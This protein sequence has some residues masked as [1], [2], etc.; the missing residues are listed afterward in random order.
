[1]PDMTEA[2]KIVG[3]RFR[4]VKGLLIFDLSFWLFWCVVLMFGSADG[5]GWHILLLTVACFLMFALPFLPLLNVLK[6]WRAARRDLKNNRLMEKRIR[7][8]VVQYKSG[9]R[10][11]FCAHLVDKDCER[12]ELFV[13]TS[14]QAFSLSLWLKNIP[15]TIEYLEG[16]H[17]AVAVYLDIPST[18]AIPTK[19]MP[20]FEAREGYTRFV[21][22]DKQQNT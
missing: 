8:T 10:G 4:V 12:Y 22:G 2:K 20:L 17:L 18:A 13:K 15:A 19:L 3:R 14:E 1:M 16:S 11:S 5:A 7:L 9:Y 6:Q 21:K